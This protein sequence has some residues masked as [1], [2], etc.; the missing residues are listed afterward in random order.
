MTDNP[1]AEKLFDYNSTAKSELEKIYEY[2]ANGIIIRCKSQWH[3]EGQKS[4]KY[5]F[6]LEKRNKVKSHIRKLCLNEEHEETTNPKQIL[7]E[8]KQFYSSHYRKKVNKTE[9]DCML[10]LEDI[11]SP[12]LTKEA[13]T[14]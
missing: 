8:L 10:H 14:A 13:K 12:T 3:E 7:D 4:T 11:N 1:S 2:I 9:Q 5:F 6:S